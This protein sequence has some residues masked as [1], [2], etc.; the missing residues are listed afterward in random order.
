MV[1]LAVVGAV[2]LRGKMLRRRVLLRRRCSR[3]LMAG[4]FLIFRRRRIRM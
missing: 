1:V 3:L 2:V 4:R